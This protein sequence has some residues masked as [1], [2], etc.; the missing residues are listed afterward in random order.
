[1]ICAFFSFLFWLIL[2]FVELSIQLMGIF[3]TLMFNIFAVLVSLAGNAI[4]GLVSFLTC[5]VPAAIEGG[6]TISASKPAKTSTVKP[7]NRRCKAI[8]KQIKKDIRKAQD[9][10]EYDMLMMMEVCSDDW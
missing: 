10:L 7:D 6:A 9:D 5:S 3:L 8:D 1:M 4:I 2:I